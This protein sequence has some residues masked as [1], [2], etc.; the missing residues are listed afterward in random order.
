MTV[1]KYY[2]S[3]PETIPHRGFAHRG[4]DSKANRLSQSELATL[5]LQGYLG[6]QK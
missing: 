3:A 1:G 5:A 2:P 4:R 6:Q